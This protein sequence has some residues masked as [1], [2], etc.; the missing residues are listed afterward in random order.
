MEKEIC[1]YIVVKSWGEE[2]AWKEVKGL[3]LQHIKWESE[4]PAG[5][6]VANFKWVKG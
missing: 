4:R 2:S 5:Q 1:V 3:K 6:R